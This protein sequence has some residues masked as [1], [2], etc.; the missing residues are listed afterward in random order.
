MMIK[1]PRHIRTDVSIQL[2]EIDTGVRQYLQ[3]LWACEAIKEQGPDVAKEHWMKIAERAW[4]DF[5][6]DRQFV[7]GS[8]EFSN[9]TTTM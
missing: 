2:A 3:L 8:I 7:Q 6:E 1:R 9:G 5:D 4:R